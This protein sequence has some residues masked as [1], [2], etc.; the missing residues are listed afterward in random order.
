MAGPGLDIERYHRQGYLAGITIYP[1]NGCGAL[2]QLYER[3][4]HLLPTGAATELMDWWHVRDREL[5]EVCTEPKTLDCVEAILGPDFYLWGTQFFCKDPGDTKTVPWHQDGLYWPLAPQ[6][7][8]TVWLAF[9][10][11]H[12]QN[13]A[14]KVIPGTHRHRLRHVDSGRDTDV[15]DKAVAEVREEDAVFVTLKAG[16]ISLHDGQIVHG[17]EPNRSG[18]LRCGLTMRFSAGEVK[19]DTAV[20][21]F[22]K[23]FW[24]RGE[25]RWGHNPVG[26]PPTEPMTEFASVTP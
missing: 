13:G 10:D 22:F 7:T 6:Q 20:W 24:V 4:R 19:V 2:L 26:E 9:T 21:P 15:L 23:S 1:E 5:W 8:A 3:L 14:M 16:Q 18:R 12:P 11:S 25:D 17:S